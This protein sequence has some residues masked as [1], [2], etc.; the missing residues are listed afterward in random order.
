MKPEISLGLTIKLTLTAMDVREPIFAYYD[1]VE[2]SPAN[3]EAEWHGQ[4]LVTKT[5]RD[6]GKYWVTLSFPD[7]PDI[8]CLD[9]THGRLKG[10]PLEKAMEKHGEHGR[11]TWGHEHFITA[12]WEGIQVLEFEKSYQRL[13]EILE[14]KF[15]KDPQWKA[16]GPTPQTL[17]EIARALK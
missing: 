5:F 16:Y 1:K 12:T 17:E 14:E 15:S 13:K 2:E 4:P 6:N 3:R 8:Y 9:Q 10:V 7:L 11:I